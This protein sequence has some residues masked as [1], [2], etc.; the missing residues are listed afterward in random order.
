MSF[1]QGWATSDEDERQR[2][3]AR[4]RRREDFDTIAGERVTLVR[5]GTLV[6]SSDELRTLREAL[7]PHRRS[8]EAAALLESSGFDAEARTVLDSVLPVLADALAPLS[9]T[10]ARHPQLAPERWATAPPTA[11]SLLGAI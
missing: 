8:L 7:A 2:R 5:E 1:G 11:A 3:V 9:A 4:G 6:T 10:T